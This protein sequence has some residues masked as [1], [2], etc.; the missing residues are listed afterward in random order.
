[1]RLTKITI[2]LF[3]MS[4]GSL[5]AASPVE[6]TASAPQ[7]VSLSIYDEGFALVSELRRLTVAQGLNVVRVDTLPARIDPSS[8]SHIPVTGTLAF[9]ILE[10]QFRHDA[11]DLPALLRRYQGQNIGVIAA[12]Q[13]HGGTLIHASGVGDASDPGFLVLGQSAGARVFLELNT[14]EHVILPDLKERAVLPPTLFWRV[15]ADAEGPQ[16][17]R[18]TYRVDGLNWEAA[19]AVVLHEEGDTAHFSGRIGIENQTGGNFMNAQIQLVTTERGLAREQ[20]RAAGLQ[21]VAA[22][23]AAP[24][25]A[26]RYAYGATQPA[27]EEQIKGMAPVQTYRMPTNTGW[28]DGDHKHLHWVRADALPVSRFYVY[29]GVRFDRFQRHR[30]NDWNYG[31]ESHSVVE[32]HLNFENVAAEGLGVDLPPGRFRL[33][34]RQR[35]GSV[36]WLGEDFMLPVAMGDTGHVRLG[37]ARGLR[38]ERERTGYTEITP[39]RVYEESFQILVENETQETV[40]IRVVEHLYRWHEFEIVRADAEFEPTG[41]QTIEFRPTLRPGGRRTIH[42]TVRYSW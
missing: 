31:T 6:V 30:R 29:D 10:Q 27:F 9:Q 35:D 41:P 7:A 4:V 8:V 24:A 37:P 18:L 34:Q 42:Y 12:G 20:R 5:A 33:Y 22:G 25:P 36:E 11:K 38:G 32:T 16:N 15:E 2:M 39:L 3:A 40:E 26:L 19:Y 23:Q 1:M 17:I 21:A 14:I 28:Q 13:R